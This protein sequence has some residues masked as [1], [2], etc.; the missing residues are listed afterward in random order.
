VVA[1]VFVSYSRRDAGFVRR[2]AQALT[3]RGKEAWVDVDGIR[4][5]EV[6]PAALR[7]AIEQ[8]DGFVFIVSPESVSSTYCEQ[9]VEHALELNK[10]IVP[11]L[12]RPVADEEVPEGVR[13]RNWIPFSEA[14]EF[15]LGVARVVEALDTDLDWTRAH[16][17]WLVKALEWD[18]EGRERS[19][20]L[21]GSELAAAESWLADATKKE[22]QPAALQREYVAASRLAASRRQRTLVTASAAVAAV[23][24]GLL[25]FALVLRGQAIGARNTARS[26]ALTAR[27]QALAAESQ[28]QLAVDPERSI[29]LAVAAMRKEV[30]P[31]ALFALRGAL[32]A[33]P[34]RFRLPDAGLQTCGQY[35]AAPGVAFRPDGTQLAEGLCSGDVVLADAHTGHVI[36][37]IHV[38][39]TGGFVGY[40]PDGTELAACCRRGVVLL[41]ATTGAVRGIGPRPAS[42]YSAVAFDPTAPVLA[43]GGPGDIVLWNFRTGRRRTIR[44]APAHVNPP[45]ISLAF[46]PDGS[47]LV[48]SVPQGSPTQVALGL[49]DVRSGRLLRTARISATALAFSPD[50][51][52]I[53]AA[54]LSPKGVG[55]I[56]L[57][58][59]KTL[60]SRRSLLQVPDVQPTTLAYDRD[61][62]R[63]AYGYADGKAGLL[64]V[65]TGTRLVSY[66]GQTAAI[67]QIAFSADGRLVATASSDGTTRIWRASGDEP[68]LV[69]AG[70]PVDDLHAL[71]GR[72]EW[73][74]GVFPGAE[75]VPTVRSWHVGG[76]GAQPLR[77]S[78]T[79]DLGAVF[80]SSDG[81]FAA[82]IPSSTSDR[83]P[84]RI[85]SVSRRRIV[86]VVTDALEP[87][88]AEP[89]FSPD[90]SLIAMDVQPQTPPAGTGPAAR[91]GKGPPTAPSQ[92]VVLLDVRTGKT[93]YLGA[94]TCGAGWRSQPFSPN[95]K[96]LAAGSFCGQVKIWNVATGRRVGRSFTIGGE[97]SRTAFSPGATRIAAASWNGTITVAAV[98]TGRVVAQLTGDTAGVTDVAY[99]PDGRYLAS[100]SLDH[101]LRIWDAKTLRL[102]RVRELPD[103][104]YGVA[105][106]P[107]SREVITW[108]AANV[109]RAADACT[110]CQNAK[111]LLALAKTRVTRGLTAQ[112]RRT[113][114]AG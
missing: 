51:K 99:S 106:T 53:A 39:P 55:R 60:V 84:V 56:E 46:S 110:D 10:R 72:I 68:Q 2:L 62:A 14:G 109:I 94:T 66:L 57:L 97:L 63:I 100:V 49:L 23:S 33:S 70:G 16:T 73:L 35:G 52:A 92:P 50:G 85:W 78:S 3:E 54:E 21:R 12:L 112:E 15:E 74:T 96:L 17:R 102:L 86:K 44:Y 105:F 107:D 19:F 75:T 90:D 7:R 87:F 48:G 42:G 1:D 83:V 29:L 22:P 104:V 32:D 103:A 71:R 25:T 4:D 11:L 67:S 88:G 20:L 28:T 93:R 13:V 6:F 80:M 61:G 98:R 58:D 30:T 47:R 34:I 81:R 114:A 59:P 77:I 5:A 36:R 37:R 95:G 101:S 18:S 45:T 64:S 40:S 41:D 76:R 38:G 31:Q 91:D 24:L 26:Q 113:F 111:A 108:D 9:E 65:Q 27:S 69:D 43:V 82:T 89:T 8:S 79:N